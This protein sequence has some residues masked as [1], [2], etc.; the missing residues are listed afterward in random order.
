MF[1]CL[2]CFDSKCD[3][4]MG[5]ASSIKLLQFN[6]SHKLSMILD[7]Q[8]SLNRIYVVTTSLTFMPFLEYVTS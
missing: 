7:V 6:K 5:G 3:E 8:L 2:P 1:S 4:L